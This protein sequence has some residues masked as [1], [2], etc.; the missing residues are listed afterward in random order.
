MGL[1]AI[2]SYRGD[3]VLAAA[4]KA[5]NIPMVMSGASLIRMEE[6]ADAN[7]DAWFQAYLFGEPDSISLMLGRVRR[8]GFGTLVVTVDAQGRANKDNYIRCGF[9]TPL[10]PSMQLFWDGLTRPRWLAGV[11]LPTLLRHGMP[12]F[13]NGSHVRG[14]PVISASAE[15]QFDG[16]SKFSWQHIRQIRAE[17]EGKLVIKGILSA[18]DA[19]IARE[20]G[21]DAIIVSNHGGRQLDGAITALN[22]LEEIVR[23]VPGYPVM[24]D[25]GFR[26]G[27]DVMKALA[28]GASFVFVGRPF[29]YAAAVAGKPG[30]ERAIQLLSQEVSRNLAMLGYTAIDQIER[31]CLR[32]A[33][34]RPA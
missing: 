13:E 4:A 18:P 20:H 15:R 14:A 27:T 11:F 16:R 5:A 6:V 25:G 1:A 7:P 8:A 23:Q 26:R 29:A 24:I 34:G 2:C 28:L 9:T 17:W 32:R 19:L 3:L 21:V 33:D 31:D 12:H 30:V 10:R 22:I